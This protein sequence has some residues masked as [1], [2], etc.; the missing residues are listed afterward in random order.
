MSNKTEPFK[1]IS[2]Q[3]INP[4]FF[5]VGEAYRWVNSAGDIRTGICTEVK[6][7]EVTFVTTG[8]PVTMYANYISAGHV[9]DM[10]KLV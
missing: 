3:V 9:K 4:E 2:V 1:T 10:R 8:K 6:E 5:E 7:E